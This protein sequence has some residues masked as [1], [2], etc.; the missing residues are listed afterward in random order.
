MSTLVNFE[1]ELEGREGEERKGWGESTSTLKYR[2]I[3]S[4]SLFFS[5]KI[6]TGRPVKK[7]KMLQKAF[8]GLSLRAPQTDPS[9]NM[10]TLVNL[11]RRGN[12]KWREKGTLPL[13]CS[14]L[15]PWPCS[16]QTWG[17]WLL[18]TSLRPCVLHYFCHFPL[19][20]DAL[21]WPS[22][23]NT[24]IAPVLFGLHF[25]RNS[26]F[27]PTDGDDSDL[28]KSWVYKMSHYIGINFLDIFATSINNL[29]YYARAKIST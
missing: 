17:P 26:I 23:Q 11:E 16:I 6:V 3:H 12:G 20:S 19:F 13:F 8:G 29:N 28:Q 4:F 9:H 15:R 2:R 21:L 22:L 24:S 10:S 5:H 18:L 14:S 27:D 7:P 1:R 25:K